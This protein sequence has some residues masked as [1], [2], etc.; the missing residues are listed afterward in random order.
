LL[1]R[2]TGGCVTPCSLNTILGLQESAGS[3]MHPREL[4]LYSDVP[5]K[6]QKKKKEL[7]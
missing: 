7:C 4:S 6:K 3:D 2:R 5:A 1:W